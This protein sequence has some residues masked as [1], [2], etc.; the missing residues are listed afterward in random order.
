MI[1]YSRR[2]EFVG[3]KWW[4]EWFNKN[5]TRAPPIRR[6]VIITICRGTINQNGSSLGVVHRRLFM[7]CSRLLV[8]WFASHSWLLPCPIDLRNFE[9]WP[10]NQLYTLHNKNILTPASLLLFGITSERKFFSRLNAGEQKF[11]VSV[12]TIL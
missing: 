3:W 8:S 9:T 4:Q 1:T 2:V 12:R 7:M 10:E 6:Y 5:L 11:W